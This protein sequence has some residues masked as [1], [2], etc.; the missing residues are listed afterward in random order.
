MPPKGAASL[1][2]TCTYHVAR[3]FMV[4]S[5]ATLHYWCFGTGTLHHLRHR[6][7]KQN[8]GRERK[9]YLLLNTRIMFL[10]VYV[11]YTL[12]QI[13]F[14]Y[15]DLIKALC[16]ICCAKIFGA[17]D[18]RNV[19]SMGKPAPNS[20]MFDDPSRRNDQTMNRF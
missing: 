8:L 9:S 11:R 19:I 3:L 1:Y 15:T 6:V 2:P 14:I 10:H 7:Q 16:L 4:A 12:I 5:I 13:C 20:S 18:V 17:I